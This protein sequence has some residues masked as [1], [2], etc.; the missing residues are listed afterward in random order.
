[1]IA[2]SFIIFNIILTVI[3][4]IS[5]KL[6]FL[7]GLVNL[8]F[9]LTPEDHGMIISIIIVGYYFLLNIAFFT[10]IIIGVYF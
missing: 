6:K 10:P 9:P 2:N 7:Q 1:M 8:L 3:L 4:F 5:L